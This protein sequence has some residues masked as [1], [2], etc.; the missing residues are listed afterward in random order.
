MTA[1]IKNRNA[2][3][4]FLVFAMAFL[5]LAVVMPVRVYANSA[6]PPMF[7]IYSPNAPKD[8]EIFVLTDEGEKD[9]SMYD[10]R[11][12]LW[13]TSF[14]IDFDSGGQKFLVRSSEKS[15]ELDIPPKHANGWFSRFYTLD[16]KAEA[17]T[18]NIS[19]LRAPIMIGARVLLTLLIECGFYFLIK[20]RAKR[21]YAAFIAV[22][23]IT[24]T[25]VNV[26]VNWDGGSVS[27]YAGYNFMVYLFME[28]FVFI[29][30]MIVLPFAVKEKGKWVVLHA[31][32]ANALSM[33]FGGIVLMFL[34][35]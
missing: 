15:F 24:Q 22:N 7:V 30:E 11:M 16:F 28:F 31:F 8:T 9:A 6:E 14:F 34:P 2:A 32:I 25:F 26:I 10:K 18:E 3:K 20:Y 4:K 21:S 12:Q 23:L 19:P 27:F 17:L 5:L 33:V 35:Y 1:R 13:E 29:F